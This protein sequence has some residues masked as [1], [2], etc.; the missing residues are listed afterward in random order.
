MSTWLD[1]FSIAAIVA[2]LRAARAPQPVSATIGVRGTAFDAFVDEMGIPHVLMF[3]GTTLLK[4]YG[5]DS[6]V[7]TGLCQMVI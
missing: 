1:A 4:S 2:A 5:G 6:E 7:L 3:L